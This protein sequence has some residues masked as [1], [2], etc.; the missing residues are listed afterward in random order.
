M[1]IIERAKG[2]G[3]AEMCIEFRKKLNLDID[4]Y[5]DD[6]FCKEESCYENCPVRKQESLQPSC[7]YTSD[8]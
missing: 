7:E 6:I 1:E 4:V 8:Y 2:N 3:L 5:E